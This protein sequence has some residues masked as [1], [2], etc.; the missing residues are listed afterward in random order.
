ETRQALYSAANADFSNNQGRGRDFRIDTRID[1]RFQLDNIYYRDLNGIE[2][3]YDR[4]HLTRRAAVAWGATTKRANDASLDSCFF[5]NISLQHK[6]FNQDEWNALE[7]EIQN[8][9]L[10][11]NDRFNIFTGPV[12]TDLDRVVRP[13]SALEPGR[14]PSAY[15]KIMTYIGQD[16]QQIEANAF[17]VFQDEVAISEMGQVLGNNDIQPFALF[18]TST[19]LI[20]EL[21]GLKFP[22]LLFDNNPM[23][24]F[25]NDFTQDNDIITPQM[26]RVTPLD[27]ESQMIFSQ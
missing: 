13:T 3:P 24:F 22:A 21:T 11:S 8:T 7:Q 23:F 17:L 2:N 18:Q 14:V 26:N 19:T 20:E 12:F 6:N 5:P 1:R 9:N 25:E 10:D 15:W 27:D 16:S 4:G